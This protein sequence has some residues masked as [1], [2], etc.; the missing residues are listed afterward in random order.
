MFGISSFHSAD[1]LTALAIEESEVFPHFGNIQR[2]AIGTKKRLDVLEILS[3]PRIV[4][5]ALQFERDQ[6]LDTDDPQGAERGAFLRGT[7]E[8]A[9]CHRSAREKEI[10]ALVAAQIVRYIRCGTNTGNPSR[11]IC[12]CT[13]SAALCIRQQIYIAGTADHVASCERQAADERETRVHRIQRR[14]DLFNL[15]PEPG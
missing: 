8:Q 14:Y 13:R 12:S 11:T 10:H 9:L 2:F 3:A 15:R 5:E 7:G 1:R 4:H 6:S